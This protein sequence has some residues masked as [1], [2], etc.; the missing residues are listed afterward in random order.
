M[1]Q[2]ADNPERN[3]FRRSEILQEL[4]GWIEVPMLVLSCMWLVLVLAEL[5]WG[6]I[7]LRCSAQDHLCP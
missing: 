3:S 5:V 7:R 2:M 6:T 1:T 4:E